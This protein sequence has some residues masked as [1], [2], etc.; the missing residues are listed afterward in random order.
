[1]ATERNI[2]WRDGHGLLEAALETCELYEIPL[3]Q[4]LSS[5]IENEI[6]G[7]IEKQFGHALRNH[8]ASKRGSMLPTNIKRVFEGRTPAATFGI[9]NPIQIRLERAR[10]TGI[11]QGAHPNDGSKEKSEYGARSELSRAGRTQGPW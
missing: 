7:F 5:C 2:H 6:K 9:L 4:N 8:S 1:M 11:R 3:D 10:I